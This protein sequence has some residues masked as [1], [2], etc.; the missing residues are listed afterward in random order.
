MQMT[1]LKTNLLMMTLQM[2]LNILPMTSPSACPTTRS[3]GSFSAGS[4]HRRVVHHFLPVAVHD[5]LQQDGSW[6]F[7]DAPSENQ[8]NDLLY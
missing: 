5:P 7:E 3:W 1:L 2:N 8:R 4:Y 6:E